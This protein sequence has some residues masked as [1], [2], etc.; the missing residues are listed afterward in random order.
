[1]P[2]VA[3]TKHWTLCS[4]DTAVSAYPIQDKF[5]WGEQNISRQTSG[6]VRLRHCIILIVTLVFI[7]TL[8]IICLRCP[9]L[10]L[11]VCLTQ[12]YSA[13]QGQGQMS[14]KLISQAQT[15]SDPTSQRYHDLAPDIHDG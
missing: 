14:L 3:G 7:Q 2:I 13:S 15:P 5:L 12:H 4:P 8:A 10:P 11:T 1:M 9:I 6:T